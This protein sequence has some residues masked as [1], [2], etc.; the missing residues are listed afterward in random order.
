VAVVPVEEEVF[1]VAIIVAVIDF[2]RRLGGWSGQ[3]GGGG[4]DHVD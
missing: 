3:H 2:D 1:V 4:S